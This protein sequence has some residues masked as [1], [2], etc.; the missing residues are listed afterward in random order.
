M[1]LAGEHRGALEGVALLTLHLG[2]GTAMLVEHRTVVYGREEW[3]SCTQTVGRVG[4]PAAVHTRDLRWAN[5]NEVFATRVLSIPTVVA[6]CD[7]TVTDEGW[8]R[9]ARLYDNQQFT[10]LHTLLQ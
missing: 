5:Q 4:R 9:C 8:R 6:D 2:D 7:V 10:V 1:I 3:T